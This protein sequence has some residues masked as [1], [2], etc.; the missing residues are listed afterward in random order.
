VID[1]RPLEV[2]FNSRGFHD[3]ERTPDARGALRVVVLGDSFMEAYGVAPEEGFA[4]RLEARLRGDRPEVEVVNLGV[5]GYGTLQETLVYQLEGRAFAP[6]LVLLAFYLHNDL[7]DNSLEIE[8]LRRP[9]GEK[10]TDRPFL[11]PGSDAD[12]DVSIV[13]VDRSLARYQSELARRRSWWWRAREVSHVWRL[14]GAAAIDAALRAL[15]EETRGD[16]APADTLSRRER[17]ALELDVFSCHP[18]EEYDRAWQV[19]SRILARL[20]RDVRADGAQLVVFSAPSVYESAA[21]LPDADAFDLACRDHPPGYARLRAILTALEIPFIDLLPAFQHHAR[22][23][24]AGLF[25]A[26]SHWNAAG[27]AL[28]A[29]EVAR[30]LLEL[31]VPDGARQRPREPDRAGLSPAGRDPSSPRSGPATPRD[32]R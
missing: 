21:R 26:D 18:R 24:S 14:T 5:S 22:E 9:G 27:H 16:A 11:L 1:G 4:S 28:A 8:T 20:A 19:T 12:W 6:A 10:A 32:R 17:L 7:R 2:A 23:R 29:S 15:H 30:G 3:A 25:T 13:D 31:G